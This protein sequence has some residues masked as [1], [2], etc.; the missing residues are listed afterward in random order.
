LNFG[1]TKVLKVDFPVCFNYETKE[2]KHWT[3]LTGGVGGCIPKQAGWL[4]MAFLFMLFMELDWQPTSKTRSWI[5]IL[6]IFRSRDT[7]VLT[8]EELQSM[9]I[10]NF[11]SNDFYMAQW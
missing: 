2:E 6:P 9:L 5:S 3:F 10:G 8:W 7:M 11:A 4:T 1:Q